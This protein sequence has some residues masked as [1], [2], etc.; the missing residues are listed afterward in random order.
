MFDFELFRV[1]LRKQRSDLNLTVEQVAEKACIDENNLLKI[2]LGLGR[3][4]TESVV[5]I[6]NAFQMSFESFF[7]DS[8][9]KIREYRINEI[10]EGFRELSERDKKVFLE[11]LKI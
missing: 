5:S 2:E 11:I 7:D 6:L 3:P 4:N 1:L 9:A 8:K 10:K